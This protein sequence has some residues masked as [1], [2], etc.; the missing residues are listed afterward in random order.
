[1]KLR[2]AMINN[3]YKYIRKEISELTNQNDFSDRG[4]TDKFL[5]K[6]KP[7]DVEQAF[8][9]GQVDEAAGKCLKMLRNYSS[10]PQFWRRVAI[11]I[12]ERT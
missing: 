12:V 6:E 3:D 1:V 9:T 11:A 2:N 5:S 8:I 7:D 4:F 10:D